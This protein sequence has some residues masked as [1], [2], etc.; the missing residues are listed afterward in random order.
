[1]SKFKVI[2]RGVMDLVL[3]LAISSIPIASGLM[4]MH[5]HQDSKLRETARVSAKE[6]IFSVDLAINRLHEAA[7]AAIPY[8]GSPCETAKEHLLKQ[9]QDVQ[10]L[11]ALALVADGRTYCDTLVPP[12]END[13]LYAALES[14]IQLIFDSPA[15]PNAV[16]VAYQLRQGNLS[17]IA[18]TYGM[19]LR[20]ELRAFQTGVVLLLEFGDTYIWADGD[21]RDAVR[22]SQS[23]FFTTEHSTKFG[24]T[25]KVGYPEG[26]AANDRRQA[27]TQVLPSLALVGII[28]G[29]IFYWS[30][31]RQRRSRGRTAADNA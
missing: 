29:S 4:V 20:N 12:H 19:E 1:M 24:Y 28:T 26:F 8:A 17:V 23:E 30:V 5:Y 2:G 7:T 13:L 18:S 14:P 11:R 16:L 3:T 27:L 10:Y 25:V 22:P 21:S 15:T 31:F 6:A 9:I